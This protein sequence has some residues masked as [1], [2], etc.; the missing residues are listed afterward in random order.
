MGSMFNAASSFNQS[1]GSWQLRKAGVDMTNMFASAG[2]STS[3]WSQTLVGWA[4]WV[5]S[6][7]VDTPASVSINA[8]PSQYSTVTYGSGTYTTGAAARAYLTG[9]T[10]SWTIVDGGAA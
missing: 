4:N 7:A 8:S 5:A 6:A 1:L 9:G 3:N 2:M 10:P